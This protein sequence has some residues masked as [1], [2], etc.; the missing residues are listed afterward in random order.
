[1]IEAATTQKGMQ[2]RRR[3]NLLFYISMVALPLLQFAIF[4]IYVKGNSIILSFKN[5]TDNTHFTLDFSNYIRVFNDLTKDE[6]II[7]ALKNSFIFYFLTSIITIPVSLTI[8]FYIYKK[9]IGYSVFKV[10]L[11]FPSLISSVVT[12][13]AFLYLADWGYPA[14][15]ET[16][17][18]EKV[19]GLISNASTRKTTLLIYNIFFG[20]AGNFLY[21][22]GAMSTIDDSI[23]E[24][25]KL[26]GAGYII[27]FFKI[28][29]P[30]IFPTF[31]TLFITSIA[32]ILI[33]DYGLYVMF[34]TMNYKNV[35]TIGFYLYDKVRASVSS[36][37]ELAYCA[38]FGMV[39]TVVAMVITFTVRKI[40]NRFDPFREEV[41]EIK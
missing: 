29:L 31:S 4:W 14:F 36:N 33:N 41:A 35:Q 37:V 8:S 10:I 12:V 9:F 15:M 20:L 34:G 22:S 17:F 18:G 11:F 32:N 25:A 3:A 2:S 27:E 16:F 24:A 28:T 7:D 21:Y 1:M 30:M 39:L 5:Y 6:S 19:R 23:V 40:V 13:T 26:D 38:A